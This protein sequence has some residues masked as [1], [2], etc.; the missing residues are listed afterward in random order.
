MMQDFHGQYKV[1]FHNRM[2][3]NPLELS[4]EYKCAFT[5]HNIL[6]QSIVPL[7]KC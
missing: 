2:T 1:Q 4:G 7:V 6:E 5:D 3:L